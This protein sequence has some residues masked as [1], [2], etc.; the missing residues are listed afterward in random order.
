MKEIDSELT[1]EEFLQAG[2]R[3]IKYLSPSER[4]LLVKK[5]KES[6]KE[7]KENAMTN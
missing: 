5:K 2:L 7:D 6:R 1:E 4:D 3:L